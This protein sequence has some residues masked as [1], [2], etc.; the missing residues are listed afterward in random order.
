MYSKIKDLLDQETERQ[1]QCYELIASQN[2]VSPAVSKLC[3]SVFTNNALEGLPGRRYYNGCGNADAVEQIAI[4]SAKQLFRCNHANVQPHCGTTANFAVYHALLKDGDTILGMDM[5]SGGHL[6]HGAQRTQAYKRY[7]ISTYGVDKNGYLDYDEIET[8]AKQCRPRIIIAGGSSYPRRIDWKRFK[9]IADRVN[10]VFVADICHYAGLI[11]GGVY[12]SPFPHADIVTATTNKTL[13]GP[14]GAIILWNNNN[15]T[16][17]INNAVYPGQQGSPMINVIAAKAQCF[18][19]ALDSSFNHY[20]QNVLENAKTMCKVFNEHGLHV[21]TGGTDCHIVLLNF[22]QN[23]YS[24][25]HAADALEKHGITVNKNPVPYDPRPLRECSGIRIGTAA[26]TTKG[27]ADF[28][29]LAKSIC[30]ILDGLQ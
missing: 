26:E 28:Q 12:P 3:G 19:E 22:S 15:Y 18:Y 16:A 27:T 5:L 4:D 20:A 21:Q 8:I 11:V 10:A 25:K 2:F 30:R 13:R 9:Q 14:R 7:S 24:G 6:S 29:Q 17:Q 23:K 1:H